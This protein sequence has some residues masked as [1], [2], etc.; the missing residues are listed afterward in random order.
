MS[1]RPT[2]AELYPRLPA[3][4]APYALRLS[5]S[6]ERLRALSL[7]EAEVPVTD[8]AWQLGLPWWRDGDRYF[9][10]RPLDV[11]VQ[12]TRYPEEYLRTCRA[13]L[14]HPIDLTARGGRLFV[15]DGVHRLLKARM[16]GRD[17]IRTRT[18][19]PEL[20][21]L[22]AADDAFNDLEFAL[23]IVTF[24]EAQGVECRLF[25]GWAEELL[26]LGPTRAHKDIDLLHP[27]RDFSVVD[28]MIETRQLVGVR[29]KRFHHKRAFVVGGTLVEIFLVE[30]DERGFFTDFWGVARHDW[31]D[32][33][34][35]D[36]RLASAAAVTGYRTAYDDLQRRAA[37]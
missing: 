24:L 10:V 34:V 7:A 31:P 35:A 22:I 11:L 32:D 6:H 15:L 13:D 18:L 9:A 3:A 1:T 21:S 26:G 17:T 5:W 12:P 30:C 33:V 23:S 4:F 19:P 37:A 25:G 16:L 27:A 14:A 28:E 29:A 2:W 8:L 20:L 36:G